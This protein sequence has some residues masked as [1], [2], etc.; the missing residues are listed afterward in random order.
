MRRWPSS[1]PGQWCRAG[2]RVQA[3][4]EGACWQAGG[5]IWLL[6]VRALLAALGASFKTSLH[7]DLLLCHISL[8]DLHAACRVSSPGTRWRRSWRSR[9]RAAGTCRASTCSAGTTWWLT[10]SVG[11]SALCW[12]VEVGW[13]WPPP[14]AARLRQHSAASA[15]GTP[16]QAGAVHA[17][18]THH[19]CVPMPRC[20]CV[21]AG[22][23]DHQERL[24]HPQHQV[25]HPEA[26]HGCGWEGGVEASC[27]TWRG[28]EVACN[29]GRIPC[30][31]C[32]L[33]LWVVAGCRTT[34]ACRQGSRLDFPL[35]EPG[36]W[37]FRCAPHLPPRRQHNQQDAD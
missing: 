28:R 36:P 30:S 34:I 3:W 2:Q 27:Q 13:L 4:A 20:R 21:P 7:P 9:S 5:A 25:P 35:L 24:Q 37:M 15:R 12:W 22:H 11:R 6:Q 29:C 14:C 26:Q 31:C 33:L 23:R 10:A 17:W 32:P 18:R 8:S 19:T 1:E 16:E